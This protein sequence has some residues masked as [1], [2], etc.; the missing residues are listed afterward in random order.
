M[1][2]NVPGLLLVLALAGT[3][4]AHDTWVQVNANLLRT[5]N[6]AHIDLALGNHGNEHRDFKLAGKPDLASSTLEVVLPSGKKIDLKPGLTDQ[7]YA[8]GEGFWAARFVPIEPG[9]YVV[10]STSDKGVSYAPTRSIKSGKTCFV[11][12]ES[13]WATSARPARLTANRARQSDSSQKPDHS[14]GL[15]HPVVGPPALSRQ[16]VGRGPG[17]VHSAGS[18]AGRGF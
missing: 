10:A 11:A 16:A 14:H 5:G 8:P 6:T 2:P 3:A 17:V 7:G 13:G 1:K 9:L 12:S 4:R 15:G 18:D